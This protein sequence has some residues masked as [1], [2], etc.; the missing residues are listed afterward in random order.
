MLNLSPIRWSIIEWHRFADH[1]ALPPLISRVNSASKNRACKRHIAIHHVE[2]P[3]S[4]LAK[5]WGGWREWRLGLASWNKEYSFLMI[6]P[7]LYDISSFFWLILSPHWTEDLLILIRLLG[8]GYSQWAAKN[9]L[10]GTN[11][12]FRKCKS[13]NLAPRSFMAIKLQWFL[14][15]RYCS[16]G[17]ET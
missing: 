6:S 11:C 12:L 1:P 2:N 14:N 16:M 8:D 9:S 7:K 10:R 5:R 3:P 4:Q 17:G 15:L 13:A